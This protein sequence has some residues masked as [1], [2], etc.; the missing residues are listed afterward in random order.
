MKRTAKVSAETCNMVLE[1]LMTLYMP[2][3]IN[4]KRALPGLGS[5]TI[6]RALSILQKQGRVE[7]IGSKYAEYKVIRK[8][9]A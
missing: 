7:K 8:G 1:T 9:V 3:A 2:T 4:L 6:Y 5:D